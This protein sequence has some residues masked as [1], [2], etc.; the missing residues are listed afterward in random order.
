[1]TCPRV[2]LLLC[3]VGCRSCSYIGLVLSCQ[4]RE[5]NFLLL[6]TAALFDK[7]LL[8][9]VT[10]QFALGDVLPLHGNLMMATAGSKLPCFNWKP[11]NAAL[12]RRML[13][14]RISPSVLMIPQQIR[15]QP[16]TYLLQCSSYQFCRWQEPAEAKVSPP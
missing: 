14:I 2:G 5:E 10:H 1:M 9:F 6:T 7:S 8:T 15:Q 4:D 3:V 12:N 13:H 16:W 11:K